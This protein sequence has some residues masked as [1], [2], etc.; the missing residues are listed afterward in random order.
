[1]IV[2]LF[3][4][5]AFLFLLI[6]LLRAILLSGYE[7]YRHK[8]F[9]KSQPFFKTLAVKLLLLQPILQKKL[10]SKAIDHK[11]YERFKNIS[12]FYYVLIWVLLFFVLIL[13]SNIYLDA[14]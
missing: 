14:F 10:P 11:V 2:Y 13:A 12:R 1:M 3:Y 5:V 6:Y 8:K 7:H 4:I 9:P